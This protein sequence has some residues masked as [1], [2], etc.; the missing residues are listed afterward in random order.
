LHGSTQR[1]VTSGRWKLN[2]HALKVHGFH[3]D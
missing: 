3:H 2:D 1:P